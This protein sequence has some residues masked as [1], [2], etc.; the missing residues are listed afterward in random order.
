MLAPGY[1][2]CNIQFSKTELRRYERQLKKWVKQYM[3]DFYSQINDTL[4][5][6][7]SENFRS[8]SSPIEYSPRVVWDEV[9]Y[10]RLTKNNDD[11]VK[12]KYYYY[13]SELM[14]MAI[15]T[16]YEQQGIS[17]R[18]VFKDFLYLKECHINKVAAKGFKK[19]PS[20]WKPKGRKD[21]S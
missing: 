15:Y 12:Y 14:A 7:T 9:K 19:R 6:K 16:E 3:K 2:R 17:E 5:K 18:E 21:K 10:Q 13:P 8:A 20:W 1:K 4:N 11:T